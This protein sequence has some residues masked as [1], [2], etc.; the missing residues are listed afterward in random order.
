MF[1]DEGTYYMTDSDVENI[2]N[3]MLVKYG[4]IEPKQIVSKNNKKQVKTWEE[5]RDYLDMKNSEEL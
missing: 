5:I 4:L 1:G 3:Q 2:V